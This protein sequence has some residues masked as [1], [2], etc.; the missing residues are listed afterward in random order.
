MVHYEPHYLTWNQDY[1]NGAVK[2]GGTK[3]YYM[4]I[5]QNTIGNYAILLNKTTP[6][7]DGNGDLNISM[8]IH[9]GAGLRY[10][11]RW[12]QPTPTRTMAYSAN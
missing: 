9:P 3:F 8:I 5:D 2:A 10:Y 12:V 7:G 4:P 1:V 11:K 6:Y